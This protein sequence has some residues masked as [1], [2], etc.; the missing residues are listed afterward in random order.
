MM[1]VVMESVV[2]AILMLILSVTITMFTGMILVAIEKRR[3]TNVD[4]KD[5][6]MENAVYVLM[7]KPDYALI[8]MGFVQD[9]KKNVRVPVGLA[10]IIQLC[11][12][13]KLLNFLAM[14][15]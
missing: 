10:V 11:L 12:D 9:Q 8:K 3:K 15:F 1:D 13:M 2:F 7:E 6:V 5:V 4:L 14:I